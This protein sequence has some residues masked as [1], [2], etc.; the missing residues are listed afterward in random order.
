MAAA[1]GEPSPGHATPLLNLSFLT[2]KER[3]KLDSV[4]KA[5]EQLKTRDRIR[6]G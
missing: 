3:T 2:E 5:D 6:L 4:L 1:T